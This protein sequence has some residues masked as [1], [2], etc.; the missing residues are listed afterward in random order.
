MLCGIRK[1]TF[2]SL[3]NSITYKTATV[4]LNGVNC[5]RALLIQLPTKRLRLLRRMRFCLRALLI[6]LPT[7]RCPLPSEI[8][9]SL[10]A[11]LIQLPT[12]RNGGYQQGMFV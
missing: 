11:L 5:L 8:S 7:K 10:R 3:V 9:L 1:Q 4:A 6:Q 12:K 2:E